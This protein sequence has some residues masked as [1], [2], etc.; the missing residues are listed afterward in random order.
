MSAGPIGFGGSNKDVDPSV[1][2][3]ILVENGKFIPV[4]EEPKVSESLQETD[5]VLKMMIE[6]QQNHF[7]DYEIQYNKY[8]HEAMQQ[9]CEGHILKNMHRITRILNDDKNN[10]RRC[11]GDGFLSIL[12]NVQEIITEVEFLCQSVNHHENEHKKW[13]RRI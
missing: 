5:T 12:E 13:M 2:E 1:Y 9:Y 11:K 6:E 8:L 4:R 10:Y 7:P 3:A